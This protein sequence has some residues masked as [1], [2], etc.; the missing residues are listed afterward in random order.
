M[1]YYRIFQRILIT[2]ALIF[3]CLTARSLW[4]DH[5]D[6]WEIVLPISLLFIVGERYIYS[7]L[8]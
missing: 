1:N 6:L 8:K 5:S 2:L 7:N 4:V 3:A